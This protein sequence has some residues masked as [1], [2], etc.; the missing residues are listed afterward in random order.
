MF[1][2][3]FVRNISHFQKSE[4]DISKKF[5]LVFL[6]NVRYSCQIL[7]KRSFLDIFWKITQIPKVLKIR[8]VGRTLRQTDRQD[9]A[10]RRFSQFC[11]RP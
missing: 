8:P 9:E 10:D 6:Q 4:R 7:I 3:T 1:S 2:T 5:T 11:E